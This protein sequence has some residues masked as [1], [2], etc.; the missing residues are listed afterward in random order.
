MAGMRVSLNTEVALHHP[1]KISFGRVF[2]MNT[3]E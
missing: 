2:I 3:I 1:A